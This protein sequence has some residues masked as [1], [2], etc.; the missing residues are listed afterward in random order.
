MPQNFATLAARGYYNGVIFHRVVPGFMVQGGDP[1]CTGKG[2]ESIFGKY[3]A[4]EFRENLTFNSRGMLGM[5]NKGPNTN[6]SQ[7]FITTVA[8]PWLDNKHTVFGRVV[9]GMDVVVAIE[10]AKVGRNDKPFEDIKLLQIDI[11]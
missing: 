11:E 8:C 7:F 5:V 1:T 3:F 9:K 10:N 4:D 6:G 2:G